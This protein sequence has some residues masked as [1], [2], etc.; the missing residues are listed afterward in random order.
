LQISLNLLTAT[1]D[2]K[3]ASSA[4]C[5]SQITHNIYYTA[6]TRARKS[7]KISDTRQSTT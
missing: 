4:V 3:T 5:N 6:A 2:V 7:L 1:Y